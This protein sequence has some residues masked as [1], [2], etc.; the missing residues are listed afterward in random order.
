MMMLAIQ[1]GLR[2]LAAAAAMCCCA[3]APAETG[4]TAAGAAAPANPFQLLKSVVGGHVEALGAAGAEPGGNGM[5]PPPAGLPALP[6]AAGTPPAEPP[7][8]ETELQRALASLVVQAWMSTHAVLK[9][10]GVGEGLSLIRVE[11][12]RPFLLAGRWV[13][14]ELEGGRVLIYAEAPAGRDVV[15]LSR[16]RQAPAKPPVRKLLWTGGVNARAPD[17][18]PGREEGGAGQIVGPERLSPS[19][20]AIGGGVGSGGM[21]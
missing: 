21:R 18:Q 2:P 11:H 15:G 10:G 3:A 17:G 19:L 9:V 12:L 13:T 14:P 20:R 1:R 16:S 6:G 7:S 5:P 4:K 8:G